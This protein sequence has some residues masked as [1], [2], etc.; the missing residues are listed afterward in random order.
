[1]NWNGC[2]DY[3]FGFVGDDVM[4]KYR[5]G[6]IAPVKQGI[7]PDSDQYWLLNLD[8]VESNTGNVLEYVYV[9]YSQIGASTVSFNQQNVLYSK[10]RPYLNK[11][12]LPD[13]AGYA[14]SEMLPLMP[15]E[16]VIT[17]E[18]LTFFLRSP[19]FVEYINGKTSGAKMPRA[20]T[21]D[22][23]AV[24]IECPPINEQTRIVSKINSILTIIAYRKNEL[25][26]LDELIKARFVEMFGDP[27]RNEKEWQTKA[28]E[29]ACKSIVDCPHSTPS[30]TS[31]DTGFMC[32]RTSIVKKNRIM[33]ED[34]EY[35]PEEEYKQRIQRKKPEK[36][37]VVYT[38]EG[39]ILG[40]AAVI[41]RDCNV[42]LGQRSMLLSPDSA[43]CTPEFISV[44]MNF[45][46]FLNN[47]LKG[48]SGSASPH[49]NV[50][51]IKAFKMIL[52]PITQQE[53]FSAFVTQVDKSKVA[54][55]TA[56]DKAQLLFDSLMQEYF[57]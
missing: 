16:K 20:N 48:V 3:K 21:A 45:D 28:L 44:A 8:A 37:D 55:Q 6:D 57:G 1:M 51:D 31:K 24:E 52:P 29:D 49:I 39:A 11:V 38:R 36:G 35:I 50:G 22:L 18:Y 2:W 54:V 40:I 53:A 27:V 26:R 23:K 32:I 56:L 46:S 41:D 15:D 33:W 17:R 7:V 19:H 5:L 34:I 14:T 42:A 30:Y 12:V 13:R 43:F 25:L 47:A 4:A 10:L 9:D